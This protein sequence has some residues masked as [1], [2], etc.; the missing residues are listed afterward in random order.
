MK[1][2]N[3]LAALAV[4]L[5][6]GLHASDAA[7]DYASELIAADTA[8][9]AQSSKA[10]ALQAFLGVVTADTKLLSETGKGFDAARAELG[11][12]PPS[13]TLTWKP[14]YASASS[15]GDLGYTWG[16]YEYRDK[17]ADGRVIVQTG[18]YVTV[19]RRQADGAWKVV[20]DGGTPDPKPH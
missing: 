15:S 19:W 17:S 5:P 4:L 20:L 14:S 6:C 1:I 7:H 2:R 18:T 9:S 3:L 16:R 10:G 11:S 12:V 13:A 8:F